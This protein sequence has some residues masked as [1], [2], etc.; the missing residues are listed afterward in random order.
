MRDVLTRTWEKKGISNVG[1]VYWNQDIRSHFTWQLI[2][3]KLLWLFMAGMVLSRCVPGG[4]Q[5]EFLSSLRDDIGKTGY[6]KGP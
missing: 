1:S 2:L 3:T 5:G 6:L 4:P